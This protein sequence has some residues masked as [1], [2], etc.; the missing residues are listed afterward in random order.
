MQWF[1]N[2]KIA[3]KLVGSFILV[4]ALAGIVGFIGINNIKGIDTKYSALYEDY[5]AS[6][7]VIGRIAI[8]YQKVRTSLRDIR[9]QNNKS[10]CAAKI[11]ELNKAIKENIVKYEKTVSTAEEKKLVEKLKADLIKYEP[12]QENIINLELSNVNVPIS[13]EGAKLAAVINDDIDQIMEYNIATG[14]SESEKATDQTN[15]AVRSMIL[16]V[17]S[18]VMV[19]FILGI[20]IAR[21]ISRPIGKLVMVT[22]QMAENNLNVELAIHSTDEIGRLAEAFRKMAAN[23]N[24]VLQ[25]INTSAHQVAAASR[26]VSDSSQALSQG[27]T[28]QASSVE[29]LS[30][31]MEEIAAETKQN[32]KNATEADALA[33]K[34]KADADSGNT[35]M[36]GMLGAME[37]INDSSANISKIIKVIDEIAFQTNILALN[38]AV[39]AARAG[40]HGKGFAV[41][42]EEVRNLAARSANAAKETTEMIEGS[43]KKV[44]DGRRIAKDTADALNNIADGVAKVAALVDGIASASNEQATAISQVNQGIMQVSQVTQTNSAT[45]QQ[46]AAAS[47][48]L[49]SQAHMLRGMVGDFKLKKAQHTGIDNQSFGD[50]PGKMDAGG[51]TYQKDAAS[52]P[53]ISL[54]SQDF[55]KY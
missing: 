39:E 38:A 2:M 1:Y 20:A 8:D 51:N 55:G 12:I 21:S 22:E 28:E 16:I 17:L 18:A 4:A 52:R 11:K 10:T 41:V 50:I 19:A 47:E 43:I 34:A 30:A 48:E 46:S 53:K 14:H 40:E 31:S 6:L 23:I 42:A 29:Q 9:L 13:E 7:G 26:Q 3:V 37:E 33:V 36:Q 45:A 44:N 54:G 27:A 5:G 35:Q 49:S 24:E 25:N 32:A 15:A